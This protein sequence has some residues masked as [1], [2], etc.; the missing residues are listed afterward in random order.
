[1]YRTSVI[2]P[3]IR[4]ESHKV[5][6]EKWKTLFDKHDI[7]LITIWDGDEP[8]LEVD[9]DKFSVKDIMGEY[10]DVIF[11][12]ND[13]VRN[14]GFAYA[15]RQ[16]FDVLMTL[17]DD[18]YPNNNDPIQEHLDALSMRVP[19]SWISTASEYMRGFPYGIRHEKEVVLSHGV[20]QGVP[21]YDAPTQ[22]V[23]GTTVPDYYKG[24]IPHGI[25]YPMCIM[26]VAF[27]RELAP[28]M[29][30]APMGYKV[31]LDR[32]AD[33]WSGIISKRAIDERDW[34]VVSGYST[35]YHSRASDVFV[36]LKKEAPGLP[37]NE[38]FWRGDETDPYFKIYREK[39]DRW[40]E[41]LKKI[42]LR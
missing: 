25:Y 3:T 15:Y 30:Q 12:K 26:N 10:S 5:F 20:W 32:F 29:Y 31:G 40:Q 13:G 9:G 16:G 33:I 18:V 11:N 36:N 7:S 41:F 17:D 28:W 24:P 35:V 23:K 19:V 1:M 14:L 8:I 42:N 38:T 22:L 6:V 2:V 37:L 39:L 27:K 21:D 34:A 4:S